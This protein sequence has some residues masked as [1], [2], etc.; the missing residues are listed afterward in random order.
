MS[1][2][3][4]DQASRCR[5]TREQGLPGQGC[6]LTR[7]DAETGGKPMD[8]VDRC[9]RVA[10]KGGPEQVIGRGDPLYGREAVRVRGGQVSDD[11]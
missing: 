4:T 1:A 8:Q 9:G 10:S 2:H 7:S 5:V 6:E 3:F 11:P